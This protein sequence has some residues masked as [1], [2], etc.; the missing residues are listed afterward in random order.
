MHKPSHGWST[1]RRGSAAERGYGAQWQRLVKRIRER[2]CDLCQP[3]VR[4]GGPIGTY[5]AIDHIVNKQQ[6]GSDDDTNLQVICSQCHKAKTA[7]EAR[8]LVWDER[9]PDR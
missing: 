6:G 7:C 3:C 8:G 5:A 1:D 9:M 2:D 4:R